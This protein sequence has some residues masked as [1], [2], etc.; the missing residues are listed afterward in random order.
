MSGLRVDQRVGG[1]EGV[2]EEL[3]QA[4]VAALAPRVGPVGLLDLV[5]RLNK[6]NSTN[7]IIKILTRILKIIIETGQ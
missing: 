2:L 6:A 3:A 5:K 4:H 1:A 7:T